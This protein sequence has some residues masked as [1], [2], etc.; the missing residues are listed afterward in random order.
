MPVDALPGA[1]QAGR[2]AELHSHRYA[3]S[4]EDASP[5]SDDDDEAE[6]DIARAFDMV[7]A[8]SSGLGPPTH[9]GA[10]LPRRCGSVLGAWLPGVYDEVLASVHSWI[11]TALASN[12]LLRQTIVVL[13]KFMAHL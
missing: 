8:Y 11:G 13:A 5:G 3:A 7:R 12:R 1:G 6:E 4:D 2:G 10:V 9:A